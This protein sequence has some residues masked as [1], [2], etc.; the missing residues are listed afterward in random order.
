MGTMAAAPQP[1]VRTYPPPDIR[2]ARNGRQPA[3]PAFWPMIA[4]GRAFRGNPVS[5]LQDNARRFGDL[6]RARS[7]EGEVYQFNHPDLIREIMVDHE[8]HNRRALVMQRARVLLGDGL[9]TSEEPL[10][11][12]QRRL[13]AP[14]F[15][16]ERVAAYGEVIGRVA[17]EVTARWEPGPRDLHAETLLIALRIVGKCLFNIDEEAEARRIAAATAAFM[18]PGPPAWVPYW[19]IEQ[20]QKLPL[21]SVQSV[22]QGIRD[23]DAYLYHYIAERRRDGTDRGDLLSMLMASVDEDGSAMSDKQLR[24]ECLTVLLAGHETT[25]NALSFALWLLAAHPEIQEEA[26]ADAARPTLLGRAGALSSFAFCRQ[27]PGWTRRRA[28]SLCVLPVWGRL[29][30]VYW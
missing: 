6:V 21:R 3:G 11:M 23:L 7:F 10:H 5:L 13:A 18:V 20:L 1:A 25:A 19:I 26:A 16:R 15:H 24:D 12:R 9:L 27:R 2:R 14:A 17:T 8:R 29:T 22:W 4:D 30:A 28:A